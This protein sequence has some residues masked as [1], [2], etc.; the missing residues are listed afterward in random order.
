VPLPL[1][2]V[3]GS[4]P[5]PAVV[6]RVSR[7]PAD[8]LRGLAETKF[9]QHLADPERKLVSEDRRV[10]IQSSEDVEI[11]FPNLN[12]QGADTARANE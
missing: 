6:D 2:P 9:V 5:D 8:G 4:R 12:K 10:V 1:L 3:S 11:A 7:D